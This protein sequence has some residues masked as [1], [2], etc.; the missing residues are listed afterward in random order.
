MELIC[1]CEW[2]CT[3]RDNKFLSQA[4]YNRQCYNQLV[5][6]ASVR[7]RFLSMPICTITHLFELIMIRDVVG[8]QNS[9][10]LGGGILNILNL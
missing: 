2:P 4:K 10:N 1:T 6:E 5:Y 9:E 7:T 8:S 3:L